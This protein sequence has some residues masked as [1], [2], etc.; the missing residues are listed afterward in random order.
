CGKPVEDGTGFTVFKKDGTPRHFC[1]HKCKRN[2]DLKRK[3]R[4]TKWTTKYKSQ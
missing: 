4:E 3:P 2:V 1:S